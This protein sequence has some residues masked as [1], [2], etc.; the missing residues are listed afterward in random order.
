MDK[1]QNARI[2]SENLSD[3]VTDDQSFEMSSIEVKKIN[4][5]VGINNSGK[6]RLIRKL[7]S[8]EKEKFLE[9]IS[10]Q[11]NLKENEIKILIATIE[12]TDEI[13]SF[14]QDKKEPLKYLNKKPHTNEGGREI[15]STIANKINSQI[16]NRYFLNRLNIE[17]SDYNSLQEKMKPPLNIKKPSKNFHYIPI[18]RG[19]RP[20]AKDE[21]NEKLKFSTEI[22]SYKNRT[23]YDY[24]K[25]IV[26]QS[27]SFRQ[28][29]TKRAITTGLGLYEKFADML[30]GE[31]E[32]R[33]AVKK[34]E[35][36]LS[37]HF[38]EN[39][40]ISIIPKRKTDTIDIKIGDEN[41]FP[42]YDLGDG[43]QQIIIITSAAYLEQQES[44]FFIEEPENN[45]HPGY[46]RQLTKFL[47]DET[48]HQYF[49]TTHSNHLLDLAE[50]RSDD[51][52]IHKIRKTLNTDG[53]S[54][55]RI[56]R[57]DQDRELLT[58]LGVH[59]SSV[60]L[61]NC[62]IWVEGITDRLYLRAY[63]K[64]YIMELQGNEEKTR[65][66]KFM[67][68]YHYAF[69]EYQGGNLTHWNFDDPNIDGGETQGLSALKTSANAFLIVDR[70]ISTKADRLPQ[71]QEQLQ[72][73]LYITPGKEIENMLPRSTLIATAKKLFSNMKKDTDDFDINSID[74]ISENYP[75]TK[76]GIGYYLDKTLGLDGK[77]KDKPKIFA[78]DSGTISQKVKF[79]NTA[80]ALMND[81]DTDWEL[82][83]DLKS[84]CKKIFAHIDSHNQGI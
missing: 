81:S 45:L 19:M 76:E 60:Y 74:Q 56:S 50:F 9:S 32:D 73:S 12:K 1:N 43:L 83:E 66:Q 67:E 8:T 13:F 6:S 38:F 57:V 82:T 75:V 55:F 37:K 52:I 62:T 21:R 58:E 30:L 16:Y 69:V 70:D 34:Y 51:V 64:K 77:G 33:E 18:M 48:P 84:L 49:I 22:D 28:K 26:S 24:F 20:L 7:F 4:L 23:E 10:K 14:N 72:D 59:P 5:F 80:V 79:C 78:A 41:Q 47:L 27:P 44:M 39:Q 46:L 61:A 53:K 68:N 3:Y 42:I 2:W 54:Q 36:M 29:D 40:Q 17:H 71:L 31:P 35:T 11:Y 63:M 65:L 15:I 25:N